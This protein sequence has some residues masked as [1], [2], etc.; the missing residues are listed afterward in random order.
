VALAAMALVL[1]FGGGSCVL[2]NERRRVASSN[3]SELIARRPE[4]G[5]LMP[6]LAK[7]DTKTVQ[8]IA[9]T[10]AERSK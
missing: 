5:E 6:M 9:R 8:V 7:A 1:S 3:W 10:L 2:W 4:L